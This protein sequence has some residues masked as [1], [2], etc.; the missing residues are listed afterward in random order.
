[1][2]WCARARHK[3]KRTRHDAGHSLFQPIVST[4]APLR[5]KQSHH[6]LAI[7]H[8]QQRRGTGGARAISKHSKMAALKE[9]QQLLDKLKA[10]MERGGGT[11]EEEGCSIGRACLW[12]PSG[13]AQTN[14][15]T[16]SRHTHNA[17][18]QHQKG[19]QDGQDAGRSAQ[20]AR[21][22]AVVWPLWRVSGRSLA[23]PRPNRLSPP[24]TN[25]A[26]APSLPHHAAH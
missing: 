8:K 5:S 1:M 3:S 9:A 14:K 13:G 20:G 25:P 16:I 17:G 2:T 22:V 21:F 15:K 10:R 6:P 24:P 12:A 18:R 26:A 23:A 4:A 7:V 19:R 11:Y